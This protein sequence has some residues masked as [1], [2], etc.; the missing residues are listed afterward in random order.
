MDHNMQAKFYFEHYHFLCSVIMP[1][2]FDETVFVFSLHVQLLKQIIS[3]LYIRSGTRYD[4]AKRVW[5]RD[6]LFRSEFPSS[7]IQILPM[8]VIWYLITSVFG[9][10][11][12]VKMFIIYVMT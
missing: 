7:I 6:F 5:F 12:Q 1:L 9:H 3:N 10:A 11:T 8:Q 2:G 4:K